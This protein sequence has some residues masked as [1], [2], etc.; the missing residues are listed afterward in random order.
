MGRICQHLVPARS[1]PKTLRTQVADLVERSRTNFMLAPLPAQERERLLEGAELVDVP[2]RSHAYDRG[3]PIEHVWFPLSAV[4]SVVAPVDDQKAIEVATIGNEGIVGLPVFLGATQTP[5]DT[6]C[7][8]SGASVR[9][10]ARLFVDRLTSCPGLHRQLHRF[11]QAT[12]V[13]MSQ[14]VACNHA[15]LVRQ[16]AARWLLMTHDRVG[17][18]T[19]ALTH[20]FLGLMLGVRRATVSEAASR[21]QAAG[22]IRYRRGAVTV[23]DRK[24]LEQAACSCYAVVR[25]E[26]DSLKRP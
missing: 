20:E 19:F 15:H 6:I 18:D 7:Q 23:V 4:F 1:V 26:F 13:Q 17:N 5:N 9:L 14:T 10:R 16:R 25:A 22:L 21:L 2:V 3:R 8:V 12:L 11:T 24:G